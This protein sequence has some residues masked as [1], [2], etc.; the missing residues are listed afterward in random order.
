MHKTM[1]VKN[2]SALNI[3]PISEVK[4]GEKEGK[5]LNSST[6]RPV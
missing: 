5:I 1:P 6:F 4:V 2:P 3:L